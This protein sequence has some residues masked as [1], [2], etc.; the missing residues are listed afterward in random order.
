MVVYLATRDLI[1]FYAVY[2]IFFT[3]NGLS[4]GEIGSLFIVW[5]VAGF[6]LEIPSGAWAD[7]VDRRLLLIASG[8][9]YVGVFLSWVVFP[10]YAGFLLGF[11]LWGLSGAMQSGTFEAYLYDELTALGRSDEYA[12]VKGR[13]QFAAS[14]AE[15][16]AMP[17]AA[18]LLVLGGF[19]LVGWVSVGAAVLHTLAAVALP[20][21]AKVESA[22]ELPPG[23][24]WVRRYASMLGDGLRE[25]ARVPTVRRAVIVAAA[26]YGLFSIDEYYVLVGEEQGLGP[27]EVAWL[28]ALLSLGFGLGTL[29][30]GYTARWSSLRVA[31]LYAVGA[32]V[33]SLGLLAGG[34]GGYVALA[35]G[36]A[37]LANGYLVG[38]TRIQEVIEGQA[39][40]TVTSV[41]GLGTEFFAIA[42]Y[43]AVAVGAGWVSLTTV[44]AAFGIP[45]VLTALLAT[46]WLPGPRVVEPAR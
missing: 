4:T 3:D 2:A 27:V 23:G 44:M 16:A 11:A 25:T 10:S 6:V 37:L 13:A 12:M 1:P 34:W 29:A 24:P 30:A 21:A 15:I 46:R 14:L 42:S 32:V 26:L 28:S 8:V 35:V 33:S 40:A 18:G 39:R 9:V 45:L 5:S 7:T 41:W 38:E 22:D 43:A 36:Y 17:A 19:E 20:P 31:A